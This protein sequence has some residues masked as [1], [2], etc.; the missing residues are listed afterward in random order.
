MSQEDFENTGGRAGYKR[1]KSLLSLKTVAINTL[2]YSHRSS[3]IDSQSG[4][5]PAGACARIC[6]SAFIRS[7]FLQD[8]LAKRTLEHAVQIGCVSLTPMLLQVAA[9]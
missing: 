2:A 1:L 8:A 3:E 5:Q 6:P 4:F 9:N 7:S